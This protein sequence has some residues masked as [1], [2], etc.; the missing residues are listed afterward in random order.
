MISCAE[1]RVCLY[2]KDQNHRMQVIERGHVL[3]GNESDC[4]F[5]LDE[6]PHDRAAT[7]VLG[8]LLNNGTIE[9]IE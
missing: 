1:R 4:E 3:M 9:T 8:S 7:P 5:E 2:I 6:C